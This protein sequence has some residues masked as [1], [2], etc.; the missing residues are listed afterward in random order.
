[1]NLTAIP[2]TSAD[3]QAD[4]PDQE[5]LPI[6]KAKWRPGGIWL[7]VAILAVVM[8]GVWAGYAGWKASLQRQ[9]DAEFAQIH[10]RGEPVGFAEVRPGPLPAEKDGTAAYLRAHEA[11]WKDHQAAR[12]GKMPATWTYALNQKSYGDF[13]QL[14][15]SQA[16][17]IRAM[18]AESPRPLLFLQLALAKPRIQLDYDYDT[19]DPISTLLDEVS[20]ARELVQR[21]QAQSAIA[22]I[23]G[24]FELSAECVA[25]QLRLVK[26]L[27]SEVFLVSQFVRYASATKATESL[28][29]LMA[30][31]PLSEVKFRELDQLLA[32]LEPSLK[33]RNSLLS[34][35]A[36]YVTGSANAFAESIRFATN[37]ESPVINW[38]YVNLEALRLRDQLELL[39]VYG[40]A[41]DVADDSSSDARNRMAALSAR[42]DDLS[43]WHVLAGQ[44]G[45]PVVA[46]RTSLAQ[47]QHCI[48]ARIAMRIARHY[49]QTGQLPAT[50][51]DVTDEAMP[52]IPLGL[53][54]GLSLKYENTSTGSVDSFRLVDVGCDGLDANGSAF[55]KESTRIIFIEFGK[56]SLI[57]DAANNFAR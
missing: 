8:L 23:D 40:E 18:L 51:Q 32:Q 42:I 12:N 21:L 45:T 35:R 34:E 10:K 56:P 29:Q 22:R 37:D 19:T 1:M 4:K 13:A 55:T 39:E 44:V 38:A 46:C 17:E 16:E 52:E 57:P 14:T 48:N 25:T 15:P 28:Q 20:T 43:P 7:F 9:L 3:D 53:A 2:A 54:S 33:I 41:I 47:R 30:A 49:H 6:P 36:M 27:Q 31:G 5:V 26:A 50:L 11:F 24:D